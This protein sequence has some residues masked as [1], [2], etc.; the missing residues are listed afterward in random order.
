MLLNPEERRRVDESVAALE[1]RTGA[2]V[3]AAAIGKSDNYPEIPWKA[4]AL[5]AAVTAL[6]RLLFDAARPDWVSGHATLLDAVLILGIGAALA[7]L[8]IRWHGLARLFLHGTRAESEVLQH[9]RELFLRREIFATPMR[10]GI[11]VLVSVFE[12]RVVILPDSGLQAIL[13]AADLDPVIATMTPLLAQ[14]R[15]VDA[16]CKG[17]SAL[18]K[19][20]AARGLH[21]TGNEGA[22]L[23]DDVIEEDDD[24]ARR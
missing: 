15:L 18:E 21:P 4:F 8:T 24:G 19:L 5:G 10:H 17:V 20:L 16:L 3:V 1:A 2:Q 13:T 6:A 11:L 22:G 23:A 9:A 12:R 7:L 14:G